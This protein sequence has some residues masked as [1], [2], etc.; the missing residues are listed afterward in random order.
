MWWP[1]AQLQCHGSRPTTVMATLPNGG[2]WLT[3]CEL[4][5]AIQAGELTSAAA[6]EAALDRCAAANPALN[7]VVVLDA[8]AARARAAEAD[9]ALAEGEVWGPLHGV[10]MTVKENISVAGLPCLVP[11]G[12]STMVMEADEP[13]I[14]RLKS[15]GAVLFGKTNAPVDLADWQ[16]YNPVYGR[17]NNPWNLGVTPGGSSGGSASAVAAGITAL[18]VGG[19]IGG[20]VRIPASLCGVYGHKATMGIIPKPGFA[21]PQD[22][23]VK[24]PIARSPEDLALLMDVLGTT[25]L[26]SLTPTGPGLVLQLPRPTKK[27][28]AEYTFA[29][30]ADDPICPVDSETKAVTAAVVASLR[31]VGATVS[32][33]A[34]PAFDAAEMFRIYL[35]LLGATMCWSAEGE[36]R[37][38]H[39]AVAAKFG[40]APPAEGAAAVAAEAA[41]SFE[42]CAARAAIPEYRR[43]HRADDRR[44]ELRD[45]WRQFFATEADVMICPAFSRAAYPHTGDDGAFWPFWRD[46]CELQHKCPYFFG[47]FY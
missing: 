23:A 9:A 35:T 13:L 3:G 20:S 44:H 27:T 46:T 28:L 6:L 40:P 11:A 8:E 42:E 2:R 26:Q 15:A 14:Q 30:W 21:T 16:S 24:G 36:V 12:E 32:E 41:E 17:T 1:T 7:A 47:T 45:V 4:A 5:A 34:R 43:W 29:V 39:E 25:G 18:E 31:A 19:D 33:I 38:M 22:L 10:P 37:A